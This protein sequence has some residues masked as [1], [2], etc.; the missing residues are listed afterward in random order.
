MTDFKSIEE[1]PRKKSIFPGWVESFSQKW[2]PI[3]G[4][5][6]L[7]LSMI[8]SNYDLMDSDAAFAAFI[9]GLALTMLGIFCN[10]WSLGSDGRTTRTWLNGDNTYDAVTPRAYSK[11]ADTWFHRAAYLRKKNALEFFAVADK[12]I[13]VETKDGKVFT[14]P[15]SQTD[16]TYFIIKGNSGETTTIKF[17]LSANGESISFYSIIGMLEKEEWEDIFNLLYRS[18]SFT[19]TK[20]SRI[21]GTVQ[22]LV[23]EASGITEESSWTD[24]ALGQMQEATEKATKMKLHGSLAPIV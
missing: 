9:T 23:S 16:T 8:A 13:Y 22:N 5:A 1:L 17:N 2:L 15:I 24:A 21:L 12:N 18:R 14:A 3:I 20:G 19:Q 11:L 7:I 6:V 10:W 4:V